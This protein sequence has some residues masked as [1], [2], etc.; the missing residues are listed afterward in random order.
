[1]KIEN[2]NIS[3]A[4]FNK[5]EGTYQVDKSNSGS[6]VE[7]SSSV[8]KKDKAELSDQA[9]LLSKAQ[10]TLDETPEVNQTKVDD[11][12]AKIQKG[13]YNIPFEELATKMASKL[14]LQ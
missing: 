2:N 13:E 6:S 1:M 10:S 8:S 5:T 7:N 3:S 9:R 12:K 14:G 4:S 11:L